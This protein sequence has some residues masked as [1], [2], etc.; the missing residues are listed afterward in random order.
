MGLSGGL[1]RARAELREALRALP[2]DAWFQVLFYNRGVEPALPAGAGGMLRADPA[3]IGQALARIEE[4]PA[5]GG[6][7][8]LPALQAALWLRPEAVVLITDADDLSPA[9]VQSITRINAGRSRIHVAEVT[10]PGKASP[11]LATLASVNGGT[12]QALPPVP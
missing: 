1:R 9:D 12:H 4:V 7:S 3:T 10:R 8:H 5:S 6:T 2:P 11:T